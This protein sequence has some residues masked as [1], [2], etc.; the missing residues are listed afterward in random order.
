MCTASTD[1]RQLGAERACVHCTERLLRAA[2][3]NRY[4][5]DYKRLL[6]IA[7]VVLPVR[8]SDQPPADVGRA[9]GGHG[10]RWA[11]GAARELGGLRRPGGIAAR[12]AARATSGRG[13]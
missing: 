5:N 11:E 8:S 9:V 13:S 7:G 6:S 1:A 10:W 2:E 4:L 12:A 3:V